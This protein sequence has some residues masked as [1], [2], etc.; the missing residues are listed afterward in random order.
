MKKTLVLTVIISLNL[1]NFSNTIKA[2]PA[3]NNIF[4]RAND[5]IDIFVS[6]LEYY[7]LPQVE[8]KLIDYIND[9]RENLK[10]L[11]GIK[12]LF[13][14]KIDRIKEALRKEKYF[15][16][17]QCPITLEEYN[18][19]TEL[20][21]FKPCRHSMSKEAFDV[22]TVDFFE[23]HE[24]GNPACPI[25]RQEIHETKFLKYSKVKLLR[26]E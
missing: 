15:V 1:L 12:R 2:Y 13:K 17:K 8:R 6:Y 14:L 21:L 19:N 11:S 24:N 18:N 4:R 22:Y 3:R 16:E 25:C 5:P 10:S 26:H 20:A 9:N 23:N 7:L